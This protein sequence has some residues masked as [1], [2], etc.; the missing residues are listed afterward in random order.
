[1]KIFR[2]IKFQKYEL[3]VIKPTKQRIKQSIII[4]IYRD[5]TNIS[6]NKLLKQICKWYHMSLRSFQHNLNKS[7]SKLKNW[8]DNV[9]KPPSMN[10]LKKSA[11]TISMPRSCQS[12]LLW[13]DT[14]EFRMLGKCKGPSKVDRWS[15]KVNGPGR[16]F[17]ILSE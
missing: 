16:K 13:A 11:K 15:F 14:T 10:Q 1:M 7:R 17:L 9:L 6:Q 4:C 12:V 8:A 3:Y 2:E 5:L